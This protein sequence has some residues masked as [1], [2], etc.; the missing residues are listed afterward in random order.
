VVVKE[1]K[2]DKNDQMNFIIFICFYPFDH[3]YAFLL[4]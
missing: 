2:T 1:I 3:R 4:G